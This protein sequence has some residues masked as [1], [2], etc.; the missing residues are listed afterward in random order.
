MS[1]PFR[2]L[3]LGGGGI[4]GIL[5]VGALQELS[6]HQTLNF[7]DGVYGISIGS[8]LATYI[9]FGLPLDDK[10][11]YL[12]KKYLSVEKLVPKLS[13]RDV[14]NAFSAKGLYSMNTFEETVVEMFLEVGLDIRTKTLGHAK[15]PLYII[16]SNITKGTPTI[17]SKDVP[18]LDAIKCSCCIP[19]MFKPQELYGQLYVDGDLFV[20]SLSSIVKDGLVFSLVKK[21]S[22]CITPKTIEKM[23][24]LQYMRDLY[25]MS[26]NLVRRHEKTDLTVCLEYKN[27]TSN[28]DLGEFDISELLYS[29][30]KQLD[31]FL[32]SK[33]FCQESTECLR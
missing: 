31:N 11:M 18:V 24:P 26:M 20:P 16:A 22:R 23:D 30:R 12:V 33:G 7:P 21:T 17:F 8:I 6:K 14:S 32:R 3:G 25:I 5:H 10:L 28:S 1:L 4:K 29:A 27:L 13:F 9:S 2:K 19:A 15:M